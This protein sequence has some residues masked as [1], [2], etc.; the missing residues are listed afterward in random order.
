MLM[1]YDL[2]NYRNRENIYLISVWNAL[3]TV[4]LLKKSNKLD[5]IALEIGILAKKKKR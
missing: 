2:T 4:I 3:M 1:S 5:K